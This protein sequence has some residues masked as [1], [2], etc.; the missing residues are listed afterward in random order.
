MD[1][2]TNTYKIVNNYL[3]SRY[4]MTCKFTN[5]QIYGLDKE[6]VLGMNRSQFRCENLSSKNVHSFANNTL[7]TANKSISLTD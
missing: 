6:M 5:S 2:L 1:R 4:K 7:T 3:T